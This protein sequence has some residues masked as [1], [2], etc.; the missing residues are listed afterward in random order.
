MCLFV[1][2][3]EK[4]VV[5]SLNISTKKPPALFFQPRPTPSPPLPIINNC[6]I[7]QPPYYPKPSYYSELESRPKLKLDQITEPKTRERLTRQ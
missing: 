4:S 3:K 5:F 2:K 7:V 6:Y 1:E